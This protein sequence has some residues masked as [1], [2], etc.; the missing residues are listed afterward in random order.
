MRNLL[1][2]RYVEVWGRLVNLLI[3]KCQTKMTTFL[4]RYVFQVAIYSI[5]R[6]RNEGRH[7]GNPKCVQNMIQWVDKEVKNRLS[8]IRGMRDRKYDGGFQV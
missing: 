3:D 1:A 4:T 6:E 5:W 2:D 7:G 8:T